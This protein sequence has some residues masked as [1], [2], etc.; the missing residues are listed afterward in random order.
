MKI[1]VVGGGGREH[2]IIRKLR[3]NPAATEIYAL[4][5]NAG[6]AMDA[7]CVDIKATDIEGIVRLSLIHISG[8]NTD[9]CPDSNPNR[10]CRSI[11]SLFSDK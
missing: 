10:C 5:G 4:P 6:I 7:T 11:G 9:R 1:M 3:E 8:V 2:A